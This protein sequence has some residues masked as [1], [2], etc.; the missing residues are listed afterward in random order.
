M[1][2]F[3]VRGGIYRGECDLHQLGEVGM[4]PGVGWAAG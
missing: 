3:T 2:T 4:A 1:L